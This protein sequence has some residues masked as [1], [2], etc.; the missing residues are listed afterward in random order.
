MTAS[1]DE[2]GEAVSGGVN[3]NSWDGDVKVLSSFPD[4]TLTTWGIDLASTTGGHIYQATAYVIC[5]D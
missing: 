2:A 5:A 1:C 4:A 3:V